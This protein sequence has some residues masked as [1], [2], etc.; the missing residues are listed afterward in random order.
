[1][2]EEI[3]QLWSLFRVFLQNGQY[4]FFDFRSQFHVEDDVSLENVLGNVVEAL[5]SEG[6][7]PFNHL[8][9]KD[10]QRPN[11]DFSPVWKPLD[12]FWS[13]VLTGPTESHPFLFIVVG[14]PAKIA[15]LDFEVVEHQQILWLFPSNS[16]PKTKTSLDKETTHSSLHLPLK[17]AR[18]DD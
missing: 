3:R 18:V 13:H 17:N 11:V 14:A 6:G 5:S 9:K 10:A 7:F 1:M 12:H 2:G 4:Q 15:E 8:K 16:F